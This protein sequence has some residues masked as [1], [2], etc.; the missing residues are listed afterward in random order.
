M[1]TKM[2]V[3]VGLHSEENDYVK[4]EHA[5]IQKT[6]ILPSCFVCSFMCLTIEFGIFIFHYFLKKINFILEERNFSKTKFPKII[7]YIV[8]HLLLLRSM[9]AFPCSTHLY[10]HYSNQIIFKMISDMSSLYFHQ[11][12]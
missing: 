8:Q 10:F 6:K 5:D 11:K 12:K 1:L 9:I 7:S 4:R 3:G 2:V